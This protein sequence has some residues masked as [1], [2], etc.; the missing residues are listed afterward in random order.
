MESRGSFLLFHSVEK[1]KELITFLD[2][3]RLSS[4]FFSG[5]SLVSRPVSFVS[6]LLTVVFGPDQNSRSESLVRTKGELSDF[7]PLTHGNSINEKLILELATML[8]VKLQ[9]ACECHG[10]QS[11]YDF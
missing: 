5:L 2:T 11:A 4:G 8:Y 10:E 1:A 6:E 9:L 7:G 3:E